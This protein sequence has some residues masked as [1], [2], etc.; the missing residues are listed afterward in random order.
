MVSEGAVNAHV[1]PS[2]GP[3][4]RRH[5]MMTRLPGGRA[6][7]VHDS[8]EAQSKTGRVQGKKDTFSKDS[9]SNLFPP[10]KPH[11]TVTPSLNAQF[12]FSIYQCIKPLIMSELL[13]STYLY[14]YLN[15]YTQKYFTNLLGI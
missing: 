10:A 11:I 14:N 1:A 4:S 15:R 5:A 7:L 8:Q 3:V 6:S 12:P 13:L 2:S 9:S